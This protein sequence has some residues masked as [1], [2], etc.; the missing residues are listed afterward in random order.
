M[1]RG[2]VG[3]MVFGRKVTVTRAYR[4]TEGGAIDNPLASP[5]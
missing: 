1:G 2:A 3:W 4:E 5:D